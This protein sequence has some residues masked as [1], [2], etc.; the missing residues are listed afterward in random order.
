MALDHAGLR[1]RVGR[2]L[3]TT[4]MLSLV[5][6]I[7]VGMVAAL[8]GQSGWL[9]GVGAFVLGEIGWAFWL[10]L[11]ADAKSQFIESV[12]P[13]AMDLMA[14]NLRAGLTTDRALLLA[15]RPEF[16]PLQ[17]ELDRAGREI[18]LGRSVPDALA[19]LGAR[20]SSE[21]VRKTLALIIS[22]LRSGGRLA[23]LLSQASL[24]LKQQ[25]VVERKVASTVTVYVIFIF[26]AVVLGAPFLFAVS[27]FL[28][29]T[30]S[31]IIGNI[32]ISDVPTGFLPGVTPGAGLPLEAVTILAVALLLTIGLVSC[33]VA[34]QIGTG[35][36]RSGVKYAPLVLLNV[37]L[38]FLIR[39]GLKAG[40]GVL[41]G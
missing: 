21:R 16:G 22:G 39:W 28:T 4:A 13:D 19:A 10:V 32:D 25:T 29:E 30:L 27:A 26:T 11:R 24:A 1:V 2:F 6:G 3:G 36:M 8:L 18:A 35:R 12:L 9:F 37:A 31:G 14:A 17:E 34:G 5:A 20:I 15:S 23:E 7:I 40:L 38:F 41:F 33:L